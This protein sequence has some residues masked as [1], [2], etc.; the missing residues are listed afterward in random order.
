M[1]VSVRPS[2]WLLR[3]FHVLRPVS[4]QPPRIGGYY[5]QQQTKGPSKYIAALTPGRWDHWREDWVLMQT[6]A[7]KRLALP[8]AAST[9][10]RADWEQDPNLQ[11]N[12]DPMLA[13]IRFLADKGL[14]SMMVMYDFLPKH[15]APL[16]ECSRPAWFYTG[17]N[18]ST[19]LECGTGLTW[20]TDKLMTSL[21][22]LKPDLTS[23]DFITPPASC[24][25]I[26]M[27]QVAR[28]AL[29]KSMPTLDDIDITSVQRGDQSHSMVLPRTDVA[30][31]QGGGV[32]CDQGGAVAGG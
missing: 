25:P 14:T 24:Q 19:R 10:P 1:F 26:C 2:V 6:E 29:L 32:V 17:V 5:F 11:P 22:K 16:Q 7:H 30:C 23:P 13:R 21:A 18:D 8:T 3:R 28:T 4:K 9:A 20:E 31:D 15:I 12:Y 27:D